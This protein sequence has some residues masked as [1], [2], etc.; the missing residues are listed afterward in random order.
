MDV[1]KR[2]RRKREVAGLLFSVDAN[3]EEEY[4]Y[5]NCLN[6]KEDDRDEQG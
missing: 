3:L 6:E 2:K 4:N 5:F 1:R